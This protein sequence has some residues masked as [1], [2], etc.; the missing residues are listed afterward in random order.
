M[1]NSC[2]FDCRYLKSS[3]DHTSELAGESN[4]LS[5]YN[6]E[7][8]SPPTYFTDPQ[9]LLE[10]LHIMEEHNLYL[11][12]NKQEMEQALDKH[13]HNYEE[14]EQTM[15]A[16]T[17]SLAMQIDQLGSSISQEQSRAD[18]LKQD[19]IA[20]VRDSVRKQVG[21]CRMSNGWY[22]A[23]CGSIDASIIPKNLNVTPCQDLVTNLRAEVSN[24]YESCR[25]DYVTTPTTLFML[26]DLEARL[27]DLLAST[28]R[29]PA[30]CIMKAKKERQKKKRELKRSQ[31]AAIQKSLQV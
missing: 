26:G 2:K 25:F 22:A 17:E 16:Q 31:Q 5:N 23:A 15:E 3:I 29:M 10:I 7:E 24:I 12:Q 1:C 18:Q 21:G 4:L 9:Q 14:L 8:L 19:M 13:K 6:D 28:A 27:E 11:I 20:L 30:V